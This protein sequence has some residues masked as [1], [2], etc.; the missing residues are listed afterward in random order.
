MLYTSLHRL[1][2]TVIVAAV[3]LAGC[4][5][6]PSPQ[7]PYARSRNPY[8]YGN[9]GSDPYYNPPGYVII[10]PGAERLERRQAE[11]REDLEDEQHDVMR[12]L[13]RQQK[14]ERQ[15]LKETGEW[16]DQDRRAQKDARKQQKKSFE[17]EDRELRQQQ[18]DE[19]RNY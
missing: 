15:T 19:W 13:E 3:A 7:D 14:Q 5:S 1:G 16:D 18:R 2:F 10:D 8:V 12:D 9:T 6:S 17:E 11:E 4:A